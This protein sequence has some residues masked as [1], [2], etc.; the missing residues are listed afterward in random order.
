L[1][2]ILFKD[3]A[4]LRINETFERAEMAVDLMETDL[5][6][7]DKLYQRGRE[8]FAKHEAALKL[9]IVDGLQAEHVTAGGN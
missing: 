9:M 8:S 3:I 4:T 7:L 2:A 1:C 6:K 5:L